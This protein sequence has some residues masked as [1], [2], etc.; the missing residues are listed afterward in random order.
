MTNCDFRSRTVIAP[1]PVSNEAAPGLSGMHTIPVSNSGAALMQQ[2]QQTED[3]TFVTVA[4]AS[5]S[6]ER[7]KNRREGATHG[8][9]KG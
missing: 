9:K 4:T 5:G 3:M 1:F 8:A 2:E 6:C 7:G